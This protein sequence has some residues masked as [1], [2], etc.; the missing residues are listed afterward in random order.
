MSRSQIQIDSRATEETPLDPVTIAIAA[1]FT[2]EP[3]AESLKFWVQKLQLRAQIEFAP[4]NHVMQCLLDP[5]ALF[6]RNKGGMNVVLFRFEDW[7]RFH[8]GTNGNGNSLGDWVKELIR[9]LKTA[10]R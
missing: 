3:L 9:A 10:A 1:T 2:A 5:G 4:Y 6:A 8:E 7:K